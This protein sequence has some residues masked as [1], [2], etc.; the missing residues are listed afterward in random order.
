MY[1]KDRDFFAKIDAML[2]K[3]GHGLPGSIRR[4]HMYDR[5]THCMLSIINGL[6]TG[7]RE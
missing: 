3:K 2:E 6:F 7:K 5:S 4:V 1:K